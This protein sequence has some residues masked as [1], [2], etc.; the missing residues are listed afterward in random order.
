M[1]AGEELAGAADA[2]LDFVEHQQ[3]P[4]RVAKRPQ[5]RQKRRR[6]DAQPAFSLNRFEQDARRFLRD[7]R[8][9]G[10]KIAERDLIEALDGRPEP[11]K[12][13]RVAARGDRRERAAMEGAFE[14]DQPIAFGLSVD[15]MEFARRLDRALHGFRAGIGEKDQ[16]GECGVA[17]PLGE[18][19]GLRDAK[20][21]GDMPRLFRRAL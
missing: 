4:A 18:P 17:E 19:L 5:P 6:K 15:R 20:E 21:I 9:D 7:R 14:R 3:Q 12:I 13:F 2:A 8:L 16:I 11:F 10:V 1:F